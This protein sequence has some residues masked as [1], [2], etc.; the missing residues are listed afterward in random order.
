ME[1]LYQLDIVDLPA[2]FPPLKS[3]GTLSNLPVTTTT[4]SRSPRSI[5]SPRVVARPDNVRKS[6]M[7][8]LGQVA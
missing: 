4:L 3:L 2:D 5:A 1:H 7:I 6:Y 8:G